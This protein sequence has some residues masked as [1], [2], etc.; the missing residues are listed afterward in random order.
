MPIEIGGVNA[1]L[2][3]M[4]LAVVFG[5]AACAYVVV[6]LIVNRRRK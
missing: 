1:G 5:V 4:V 6:S 3:V 2:V